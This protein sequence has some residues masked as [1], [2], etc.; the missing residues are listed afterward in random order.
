MATTTGPDPTLM[1]ADMAHLNRTLRP[2]H[3]EQRADQAQTFEAEALVDDDSGGDAV[4]GTVSLEAT[5]SL[6]ERRATRV[7]NIG[8]SDVREDF[9]AA[10]TVS[11]A[12][13]AHLIRSDRLRCV[14][15]TTIS[16][17]WM[18]FPLPATRRIRCTT[19]ARSRT[20]SRRL[21]LSRISRRS[22]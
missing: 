14:R 15:T 17:S 16:N 5:T 9:T 2:Y 7:S 19:S 6:K 8:T 12:L 21:R 4:V 11:V 20:R 10:D 1:L 3:A 22:Y 13:S 18:R